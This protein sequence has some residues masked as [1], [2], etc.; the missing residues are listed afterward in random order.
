[1]ISTVYFAYDAKLMAEMAAA[2][3]KK[4]D[5][6]RYG[7]LF[8]NIKEAFVK[9][10]VSSEG[11][12]EGDTQT[13]YALALY[14]DLLD[15]NLRAEAAKR[16]VELLKENNWHLATGFLGVK[17]LLP[18]LTETGH[19]DI[20]YR[21]LTNTTFPSWGYSVVNG[22]TTIWE[23][24][25]SYTIDE[26]F[27]SPG[28]NSFS[29]YAFGS[30]C[31]W[32]FASMAGID[33]DGA[34]FK[35][36]IIRPQ[37]GG[38][39]ISYAKASYDSINGLIELG[40]QIEGDK[41]TLEVTIP[42]NTTAIVYVPALSEGAVTEGDVQAGRAE[43]VKFLRIVEGVAVYKVESGNYKFVSRGAQVTK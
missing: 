38:S 10:Y 39:G 21:L 31:Q 18:V 30:V 7:E 33:T 25:N 16:L 4:A 13:C 14:M 40:W 12:I 23:R 29:H 42:A 11:R 27:A 19:T 20:A 36:I 6:R 43:G 37:P 1:L 22:S 3:G 8:D 32:M 26:G 35:R 28:M 15:E 41:F 2:I 17:H 34:G 24:W 9:K 5:V